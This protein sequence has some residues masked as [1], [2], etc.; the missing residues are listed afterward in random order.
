MADL[1]ETQA[2]WGP[3]EEAEA[4]LLPGGAPKR[5]EAGSLTVQGGEGTVLPLYVGANLVAR[6]AAGAPSSSSALEGEGTDSEGPP[7]LRLSS[8]CISKKHAE[9]ELTGAG[10]AWFLTDL[11]STNGTFIARGGA[12]LRCQ[13]HVKFGMS[14]GELVRFGDVKAV[15]KIWAAD[16]SAEA[17]EGTGAAPAVSVSSTD[18]DAEPG[19]DGAAGSLLHA[20]TVPVDLTDTAE[21]QSAE[22]ASSAAAVEVIPSSETEGGGLLSQETTPAQ[23]PLPEAAAARLSTPGAGGERRVQWAAAAAQGGHDASDDEPEFLTAQSTPMSQREPGAIPEELVAAPADVVPPTQADVVPPTQSEELLLPGLL[24]NTATDN[25]G[26]GDTGVAN[27]CAA[28]S[29]PGGG[30]GGTPGSAWRTIKHKQSD[31]PEDVAPADPLEQLDEPLRAT[32]DALIS[33]HAEELQ[34]SVVGLRTAAGSSQPC[35]SAVPDSETRSAAEAE[36]PMRLRQPSRFCMESAAVSWRSRWCG[37]TALQGEEAPAVAPAAPERAEDG[38]AAV[39][40]GADAAPLLPAADSE[41]PPPAGVGAGAAGADSDSAT[42][43]PEDME[44]GEHGGEEAEGVESRRAAASDSDATTVPPEQGA[45]EDAGPEATSGKGAAPAAVGGPQTVAAGSTVGRGLATGREVGE[46]TEE[47]GGGLPAGRSGECGR[48]G[49]SGED[50]SAVGAGGGA[51]GDTPEGGDAGDGRLAGNAREGAMEE[52]MEEVGDMEVEEEEEAAPVEAVQEEEEAHAQAQ[53][54][55]EGEEMADEVGQPTPSAET[56]QDTTGAPESTPPPRTT[57]RQRQRSARLPIPESPGVPDTAMEEMSPQPTPPGETTQAAALALGALESMPPPRSTR[58][59]RRRG[60]SQPNTESPDIVD[61][62]TEEEAVTQPTPPGETTQAAALALGALE[63]M[64]PPR[65]TRRQRRRGVSQPN[66]ESPDIVDTATEEEAVTQPTPP[67][68][69]TQAAALALGALESMPPPRSAKRQRRGGA[70]QPAA[71]SPGIQ[72]AATEVSTP[73]GSSRKRLRVAPAAEVASA[74][75]GGTASQATRHT[76]TTPSC[77]ADAAISPPRVM[78]STCIGKALL[79]R[80]TAAIEALGG[81]VCEPADEAFTH[82][83]TMAGKRK[84]SKGFIKSFKTLLAL[85]AGRPI[86]DV[87]WLDACKKQRQFVAVEPFLLKDEAAEKEHSFSIAGA[88]DAA[89]QGLLLAGRKVFFAPKL[90]KE[91]RNPGQLKALVAAA[92]AAVAKELPV[93]VKRGSC[94][95]PSA[96]QDVL[97]LAGGS[98][99][100][101]CRSNLREGTAVYSRDQLVG[102]LMQ[103]QLPVL[104]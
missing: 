19:D 50:G 79:Q 6:A 83:V 81:E 74:D 8:G 41:A 9:L 21:R 34:N 73:S 96:G 15:V 89:R 84:D 98:D 103:H 1:G 42:E 35:S 52:A 102:A 17:Q 60:V 44:D 11:G 32:R 27:N 65:S 49:V 88:Y 67:G 45:G 100:A 29:S 82:Y 28:S 70:A 36:A 23:L 66:T 69:T 95:A 24:G 91:E 78:F 77:A 4:G 38:L 12:N 80:H 20:E 99:A 10:Q 48:A 90:L 46:P 18:V 25:T 7:A 93:A 51:E 33:R 26:S 22:G 14:H 43:L 58:R 62:A 57:R 31:G 5:V 94:A 63:S 97:V 101:W 16:V 53:E 30:Q 76:P 68:E 104:E 61:T 2:L 59:Q 54:E 55:E 56:T 92:G 37:D 13:P 39:A 47:G 85:A 86:V 64:P 3:E 40:D 71:E 75:A 87:R 72:D